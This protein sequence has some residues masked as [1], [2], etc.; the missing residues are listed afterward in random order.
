MCV[1][2]FITETGS[3]ATVKVSV[4]VLF[5]LLWVVRRN[6]LKLAVFGL[7]PQIFLCVGP[8]VTVGISGFGGSAAFARRVEAGKAPC[9]VGG[10]KSG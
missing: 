1:Q 9:G 6:A 3:W 8:G 4:R 5:A 2:P 10:R 7:V